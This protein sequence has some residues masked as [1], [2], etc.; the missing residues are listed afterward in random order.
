MA[1]IA[2]APKR[3]LV[4]VPSGAVQLEAALEMPA[5]ARGI[6]VFAHGSGSSRMSPRNRFVARRLHAAGFATLLFDLLTEEEDADGAARFDVAL[7][8]HRLADAV[9][10]VAHPGQAGSLPIALFGA[11][12]GA[13]AALE[14]AAMPE[15]AIAALVL[16][17]GLVDLATPRTISR[18]RAPTLLV[19]GANDT[20]VVMANQ[21]A[22]DHLHCVKGLEII[23]G[24]THLFEE[25]G[26][27][28][29]VAELA[30]AWIAAYA[31][32]A[33]IASA[34]S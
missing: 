17:G 16:R 22:Y 15:F 32:R 7:L 3:R 1:A 13:A 4:F 19:V 33:C 25:P 24:A 10:C 31:P 26:A 27:L 5:D 11:S 23:A 8:S 34:S 29:H 28:E 20:R 30:C 12:G 21:S 9:R 6:V 14:V 18:V 2:S